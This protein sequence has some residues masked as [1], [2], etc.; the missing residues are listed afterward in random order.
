MGRKTGQTTITGRVYAI[1]FGIREEWVR[2][3]FVT[4]ED[5]FMAYDR[6]GYVYVT[7]TDGIFAGTM[8]LPVDQVYAIHPDDIGSNR[9]GTLCRPATRLTRSRL[10]FTL[11]G[12]Y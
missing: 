10:T 11:E 4:D 8:A 9:A 5:G 12:T 7:S 1:R 3:D 2:V 6:D